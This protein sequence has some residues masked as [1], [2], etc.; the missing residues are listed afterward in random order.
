MELLM[1]AEPKLASLG[2]REP[3]RRCMAVPF[4][5]SDERRRLSGLAILDILLGFEILVALSKELRALIELSATVPS[6]S[7]FDL[8]SSK[9]SSLASPL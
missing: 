2:V 8:V 6:G 5:M 7:G 3:W 1:L 4:A 9:S